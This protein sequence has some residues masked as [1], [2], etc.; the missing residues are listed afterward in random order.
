[1][2]NAFGTSI[3]KSLGESLGLALSGILGPRSRPAHMTSFNIVEEVGMGA[4]LTTAPTA[5]TAPF[6]L[7]LSPP[8]RPVEDQGQQEILAS[9]AAATGQGMIY[10]QNPYSI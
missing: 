9:A 7:E 2:A 1:M 5:P 8:T 10:Q 4:A 6:S 3:G